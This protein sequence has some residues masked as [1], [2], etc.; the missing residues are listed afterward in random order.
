MPRHNSP[1]SLEILKFLQTPQTQAKA[2]EETIKEP[3]SFLEGPYLVTV[4]LTFLPSLESGSDQ[5]VF[6]PLPLH[7]VQSF[8]ALIM[9]DITGYIILR[10][11][12]P[13]EQVQVLVAE[14]ER[15][16]GV[17]L[18]REKFTEYHPPAA[19]LAVR[20]EFI[21]VSSKTRLCGNTKLILA[22]QQIYTFGLFCAQDCFTKAK[23][24]WCRSIPSERS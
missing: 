22:E 21:K 13:V 8:T 2:P 5:T 3:F 9:A 7:C 24:D 14:M 1:T 10:K 19:A 15:G 17:L 20:D 11:A 23:I 12:V 4:Y 18:S 6:D 16:L